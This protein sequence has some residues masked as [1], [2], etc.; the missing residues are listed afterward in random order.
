[1]HSIYAG[2]AMID[3]LADAWRWWGVPGA[4]LGLT[5]SFP[6]TKELVIAA[7]EG[8]QV[9]EPVV[10][11]APRALAMFG[12]LL[13]MLFVAGAGTIIPLANDGRIA[14]FTRETLLYRGFMAFF[15]AAASAGCW[16][17]A[18]PNSRPASG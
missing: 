18:C 16:A 8:R 10:A 11:T 2:V 5:A 17:I 6:Y 14:G 7:L 9:N 13:L 15:W 4:L 12:G 1:M 3:H